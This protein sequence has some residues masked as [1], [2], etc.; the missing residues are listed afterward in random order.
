MSLDCR[1]HLTRNA[2]VSYDAQHRHPDVTIIYTLRL[3]FPREL[4]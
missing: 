1:L 3:G 4:W 2:V